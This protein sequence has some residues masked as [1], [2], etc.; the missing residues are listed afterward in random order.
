[1][2]IHEFAEMVSL[3]LTPATIILSIVV[4]RLWG[5]KAWES[6]KAGK[7]QDSVGWFILG[8]T[9]GFIGACC[10]N[11]YWGIAWGASFLNHSTEAAWFDAGVYSNIPFR[12]S[13]GIAAAF[14]HIKSAEKM[15][16]GKFRAILLFTVWAGLAF[17][18]VLLWLKG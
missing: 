16:G 14:C 12:Q 13:L 1:M 3:A 2:K 9:L 11:L 17:V 4:V 6:L 15:L 8:V 5:A 18:A 10:D 7:A